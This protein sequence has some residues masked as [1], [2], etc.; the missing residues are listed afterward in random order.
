[1]LCIRFLQI[2]NNLF[3]LRHGKGHDTPEHPFQGTVLEISPNVVHVV[4]IEGDAKKSQIGCQSVEIVTKQIVQVLLSRFR[5]GARV[6]K[7]RYVANWMAWW[8]D[9]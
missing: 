4:I 1:L 3:V 8:M 6:Q 5:Q 7:I 9:S 2:G